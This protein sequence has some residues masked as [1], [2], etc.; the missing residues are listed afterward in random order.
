MEED[1]R[2]HPEKHK[3]GEKKS[4]LLRICSQ[5][6]SKGLLI[7]NW[8]QSKCIG[9]IPQGHTAGQKRAEQEGEERTRLRV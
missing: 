9:L 2:K 7:D 8:A 5:H 4:E 1:K 6:S 3:Y